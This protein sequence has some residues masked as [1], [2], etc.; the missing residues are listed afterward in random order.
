MAN[1]KLVVGVGKYDVESSDTIGGKGYYVEIQWTDTHTI[2]QPCTEQE[3]LALLNHVIQT[4]RP[5]V[6]ITLT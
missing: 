1:E 6:A 5:I 3:F 2:R 4:T